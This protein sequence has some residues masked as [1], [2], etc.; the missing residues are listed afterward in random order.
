MSFNNTRTFRKP[1]GKAKWQVPMRHHNG[2]GP[3]EYYLEGELREKFRRL[4]PIHSNRRMCTW[5][6]LSFA[7]LQRFKREMGLEKDMRAVRREQARDT[8]RICEKSGYYASLRGKAPSEAC[9]EAARRKRAEGFNP[10]TRLRETNP[11]EY[12]KLMRRK[13]EARRE[14]WRKET[15]RELYGLE[16]KT[17]LRVRLSRLGANASS[18]KHLMIK[19]RNYFPDPDDPFAVCYDSLTERSPRMEATAARHGLKIVQGGEEETAT[20]SIEP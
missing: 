19:R 1:A 3:M 15:L 18:Q 20:A 2:T 11:R 4:F 7:T 14:L 10:I 6:G 12:R 8:K 13:A 5:F 16:R 9:L 17:R